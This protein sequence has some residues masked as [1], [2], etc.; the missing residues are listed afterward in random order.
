MADH[1]NIHITSIDFEDKIF[2]ASTS[3]KFGDDM[4][5][6]SNVAESMT[7]LLELKFKNTCS[8]KRKSI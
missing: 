5:D 6:L 8:V 7:Q 2:K 4:F 1:Q 3:N